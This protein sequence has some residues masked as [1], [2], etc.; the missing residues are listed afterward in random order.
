MLTP[1]C[2]WLLFGIGQPLRNRLGAVA[3]ILALEGA[4]ILIATTGHSP[5]PP[6][7]AAVMPPRPV[8]S[9]TETPC[10]VRLPHPDEV[11]L[12]RTHVTIL[13]PAVV[14]E[15]DT[16]AVVLGEK[17]NRLRVWVHEG[18]LVGNHR[19]SVVPVNIDGRTAFVDVARR[20][21]RHHWIAVDG[22]NGKRIPTITH[23]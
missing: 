8:P 3:T 12:S 20:L 17:G 15:C 22:R 21:A 14:G 1:V 7:V 23:G 6:P 13:W 11:R 19:A 9:P 16:A 4:T 18:A 5:A 2:V 10:P